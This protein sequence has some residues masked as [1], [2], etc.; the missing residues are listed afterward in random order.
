MG[1][2]QSQSQDVPKRHW[3]PSYGY[4]QWALRSGDFLSLVGR[5]KRRESSAGQRKE[6]GLRSDHQGDW[7][8]DGNGSETVLDLGY[9]AK[10]C[11]LPPV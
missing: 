10:A 3:G 6:V 1:T 2:Y 11:L 4:R 8:W 7:L 5:R 9:L